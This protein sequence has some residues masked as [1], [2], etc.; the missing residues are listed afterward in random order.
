[1]RIF[2]ASHDDFHTQRNNE[3]AP[4][5]TCNVTSMINALKASGIP[6]PDGAGQPEDRLAEILE[7]PEAYAKLAK[8]YPQ[9]TGT[10]PREIHGLLS[11]A[12]NEKF[13]GNKVTTFSAAVSLR[14]ILFR[15][16]KFKTASVIST[17]MTKGGHLVAIAG[18]ST[19]QDIAG[20]TSP[21][22]IDVALLR[23]IYL[24]DSWGDWTTGYEA[25]S[26]GFGVGISYDEFMTMAKPASVERKWAHLFSRDGTF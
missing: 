26:S 5:E 18:F 4:A 16:I 17:T 24:L 15:I 14:E 2:I 19:T 22:G 10:K 3:I 8:D 12:V 6:V 23:R 11:W 7:S 20:I 21:A 1:M 25:G 9:M 13:I